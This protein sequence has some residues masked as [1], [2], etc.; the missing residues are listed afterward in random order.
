MVLEL[1]L[2]SKS[3]YHDRRHHLQLQQ[4]R[5]WRNLYFDPSATHIMSTP[6]VYL[7][8]VT[9]DFLVCNGFTYKIGVIVL[10]I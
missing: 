3:L 6:I 7:C 10:F 2:L 1:R 5:S 8:H 4:H 9:T